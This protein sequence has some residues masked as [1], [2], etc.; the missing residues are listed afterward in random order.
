[1]PEQSNFLDPAF[2]S[3]LPIYSVQRQCAQNSTFSIAID[4]SFNQLQEGTYIYTLLLTTLISCLQYEVV[5]CV[6]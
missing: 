1:M 5:S 4:T 2:Y 3:G 6:R